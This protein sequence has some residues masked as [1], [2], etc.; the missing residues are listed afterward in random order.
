[1]SE[2]TAPAIAGPPP[3]RDELIQAILAL[4]NGRD[5]RL[6][7]PE[8]AHSLAE[9]IRPL[10]DQLAA[11]KQS[12]AEDALLELGDAARTAE[13][14]AAARA[15]K[16]KPA[17]TSGSAGLGSAPDDFAALPPR[18]QAR[19]IFMERF[20]PLERHE[21]VLQCQLSPEDFA[22]H[23]QAFDR[24]VQS[25]LFLPWARQAIEE[26]ELGVLQKRFASCLLIFRH[27][28][29]GTGQNELVPCSLRTL[30]EQCPSFFRRRK[31]RSWYEAQHFYGE[32]LAQSQW[33]LCDTDYLNCTLSRPERKLAGYARSWE[34]PPE[35]VRQ[36][37][38]L[39][40]VY[41]R[42]ICGQALGEDL[43][44]RNCNS[45]TTTT[46][47]SRKKRALRNTFI[48]QRVHAV[49]ICGKAGMPHWKASRRLWPGV[50]PVIAFP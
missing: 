43:F 37:S 23:Q 6:D 41:D 5:E 3:G 19:W 27:T 48:V 9:H 8:L 49:S 29:I 30:R 28:H 46:Y 16:E 20:I 26:D 32:P 39:E 42:L 17:I 33:V 34:L 31:R 35:C 15:T 36:K 13:D 4:E 21:E 7:D 25:L 44:A 38:L 47:P 40:D 14:I 18:D 12:H 11:L 50:F 10:V 22:A 45:C 2:E 1:M 24:L